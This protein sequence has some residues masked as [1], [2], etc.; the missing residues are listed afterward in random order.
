M[1]DNKEKDDYKLQDGLIDIQERETHELKNIDKQ[2]NRERKIALNQIDTDVA[3][4]RRTKL[5]G[6]EKQIDEAKRRQTGG[7]DHEFYMADLLTQYGELVKKVDLDI[8]DQKE[9]KLAKM[10]ENLNKRR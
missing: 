3:I 4:L 6:M 1:A 2:I 8:A 7:K 9:Q 10:E 5:A